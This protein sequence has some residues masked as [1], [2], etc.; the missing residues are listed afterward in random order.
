MIRILGKEESTCPVCG[1]KIDAIVA[2]ENE[3]MYMMKQC[4]DHGAFKDDIKED[5]ELYKKWYVS[6]EKTISAFKASAS[7]CG[8]GCSGSCNS[9]SDEGKGIEK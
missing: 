7:A 4:E 1:K 2:M 3:N 9:C 5:S 6:S 8:S